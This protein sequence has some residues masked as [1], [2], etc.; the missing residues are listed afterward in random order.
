MRA[1]WTDLDTDEIELSDFTSDGTERTEHLFLQAGI[2]LVTIFSFT[3][4]DAESFAAYLRAWAMKQ[5]G[6]K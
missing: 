5:R 4:D 1:V 6:G 3:P 2:P